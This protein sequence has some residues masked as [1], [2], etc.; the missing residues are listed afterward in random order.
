MTDRN[1][2]RVNQKKRRQSN[3]SAK[4]DKN[5]CQNMFLILKVQINICRQLD[6]K[7]NAYKMSD[8]LSTS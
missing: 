3:R 7:T 1:R 4:R 5:K 6:K 2:Q 8:T